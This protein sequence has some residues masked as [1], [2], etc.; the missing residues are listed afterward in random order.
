MRLLRLVGKRWTIAILAALMYGP[1][2]FSEIVRAVPGLS[3][4]VM[5]ERLQELC[6]ARLV[7]RE[8]DPGPPIGTRYSLTPLGE[9]LRPAVESLMEAALI[10][11]D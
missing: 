4:R 1:A 11:A 10:V 7:E 2:R 3:E 6:E 8:V 9:R 5:S